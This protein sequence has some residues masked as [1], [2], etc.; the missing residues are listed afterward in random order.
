MSRPVAPSLSP[1]LVGPHNVEAA[2][3]LSW[4]ECLALARRLGV[5]VVESGDRRVLSARELLAA[6]EASVEP[7]PERELDPEALVLARLGRRTA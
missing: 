2:T 3:G 4:R 5:R 1:I 6:L 7:T